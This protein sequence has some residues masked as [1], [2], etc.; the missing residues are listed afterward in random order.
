[1]TN[2]LDAIVQAAQEALYERA[3]NINKLVGPVQAALD[4]LRDR[5]RELEASDAWQESDAIDA[6]RTQVQEYENASLHDTQKIRDLQAKVRELE[7]YITQLATKADLQQRDI[8]YRA[9]LEAA[10]GLCKR[11][12][13]HW[14]GGDIG[15][16][17][18]GLIAEIRALEPKE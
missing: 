1:M 10:A 3:R 17:Y 9:G 16:V 14:R 8:G 2:D 11:K 13:E 6:L 12:A 18:G 4:V 5:V 7:E 15:T